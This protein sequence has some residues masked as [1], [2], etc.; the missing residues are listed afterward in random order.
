MNKDRYVLQPH[1][2]KEGVWVFTD[3]QNGVVCQFVEHQ[4]NETQEFTLLYDMDNYGGA[5][6]LARIMR[7]MAD[8][9]ATYHY[10]TAMP[11]KKK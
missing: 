5:I 7:E 6:G 8:W 4:F 11:S 10:K 3:A 9:L 2:E 1:S